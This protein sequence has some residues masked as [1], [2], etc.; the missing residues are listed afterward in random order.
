MES[1]NLIRS[2]SIKV[3]LK[4]AVLMENLILMSEHWDDTLLGYLDDKKKRYW[5]DKR[6]W[7]LF[8]QTTFA[9]NF[10]PLQVF[11]LNQGGIL[12]QTTSILKNF[13]PLRSR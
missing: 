7:H 10:N 11:N 13:S 9:Q 1:R 4:C 12:C 5:D 8:Q 2:V 3:M 6:G